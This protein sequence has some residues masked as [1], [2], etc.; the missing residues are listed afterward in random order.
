[1]T[2]LNLRNQLTGLF[3]DRD[4]L[5]VADFAAVKLTED[6][7][8]YRDNLIRTVLKDLT[9]TGMIRDLKVPGQEQP[10][11]WVLTVQLGHSGQQVPL[12]YD[13]AVAVADEINAYRDAFELEDEWPEADAL[14]ITEDQV[15]MLLTIIGNLRQEDEPLEGDEWKNVGGEGE[16]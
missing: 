12:G 13:T 8:P 14:H 15:L 6:L 16:D 7:E 5:T 10:S 9:E 4:T 2:L 1:M 3:T 11:A